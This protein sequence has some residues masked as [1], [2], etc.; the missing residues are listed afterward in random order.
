[1]VS[2]VIL[3]TCNCSVAMNSKKRL[4]Q[5]HKQL[6]SVMCKISFFLRAELRS[7]RTSFLV[8]FH[9]SSPGYKRSWCATTAVNCCCC[10]CCSLNDFLCQSESP[11]IYRHVHNLFANLKTVSVYL[12]SGVRR[13]W[14]V[15]IFANTDTNWH[16]V[17]V[18][19]LLY[20]VV[21]KLCPQSIA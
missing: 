21:D 15:R 7:V 18:Q 10:C 4:Q 14:W 17:P 13:T 6:N 9:R 3:C 16:E 19:G 2:T 11:F 12:G 5:L 1:M 20:C 8:Y